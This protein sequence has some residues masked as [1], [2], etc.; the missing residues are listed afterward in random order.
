MKRPVYLIVPLLVLLALSGCGKQ[1]L[2]APV[3]ST[4]P[5]KPAE[6]ARQ[7]KDLLERGEREFRQ[8]RYYESDRLFTEFLRTYPDQPGQDLAWLRHAQI[9]LWSGFPD[10]AR[11][12]LQYVLE[13]QPPSPL[14]SQANLILAG[15]E[16]AGNRPV[17]ALSALAQ[18]RVK[19]LK[20]WE[21]TD[22]YQLTAR[23]RYI[24]NQPKAALVAL[25]KAYRQ[26]QATVR[27]S[28]EKRLS[29]FVSG[30][31][32]ETLEGLSRFYNT[33]FPSAWILMGLAEKAAQA[34]DWAKVKL[35]KAEMAAK[36]PG[37][38]PVAQETGPDQEDSEA[39]GGVIFIPPKRVEETPSDTTEEKTEPRY[40]QR[41]YTIGCLLPLSG[42]LAEYGQRLLKGIQLALD[43]FSKGSNFTLLIEDTA[44]DPLTA[45]SALDSLAA[46]P[47][48]MTVIGPLSG[49]LAISLIDRTHEL[50]MPLVTLT[51]RPD[52]AMKSPWVFRDFLTPDEL[53]E[54][55]AKWSVEKLALTRVAILKPENRYGIRMSEM[56]AKA[57]AQYGGQVVKSVSYTPGT[58]DLSGQMLALGGVEPGS[59]AREEPLPY[60]AL[61]IPEDAQA[62]VQIA[63]QLTFYGL[64]GFVL[65][66]TNLWHENK[67]IAQA[68]PYVQDAIFPSAFFAASEAKPVKEFVEA[69]Q[70]AYGE[71]P[72]LFAALGYDASRMVAD[73]LWGGRVRTRKEFLKVFSKISGYPGV[74]GTTRMNPQGEAVKEPYLLTVRGDR[75]E[76]AP[77]E[78]FVPGQG[79]REY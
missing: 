72:D 25:V 33:R 41:D 6:T 18:C 36:F 3:P 45:A 63:P 54:G 14:R 55:L 13:A 49:S 30:W 19:E 46:N 10:G 29:G 71:T 61:F 74:T 22:Y 21:K 20:P 69:Y 68:G 38:G 37:T 17:E 44:N 15:V 16:L 67:L 65:L 28:L 75:F 79:A 12:S 77:S 76:P 40:E 52:V 78:P 31:S 50:G 32:L 60:Q 7:A 48:V 43:S 9:Q 47:E 51:Q 34:N 64:S 23:A 39:A 4:V 59:P 42:P 58:Y 57:L 8:A 56:M 1:Q 73:S 27:P 5:P 11:Q 24:L 2:P 62:V 53:L 70:E 26:A 35:Y 66:G